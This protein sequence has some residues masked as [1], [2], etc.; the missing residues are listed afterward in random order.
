MDKSGT[1]QV[2]QQ[3]LDNFMATMGLK[4]VHQ[5]FDELSPIPALKGFVS[6]SRQG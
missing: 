5:I 2:N 4:K 1:T 3:D 6:G